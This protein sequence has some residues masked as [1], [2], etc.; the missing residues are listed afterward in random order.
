MLTIVAS[1][2]VLPTG[3]A[4]LLMY[5]PQFIFA[6][7]S[8]DPVG[9]GQPVLIVTWTSEMAMPAD[10][11]PESGAPGGRECWTGMS[12]TITD[13]DG[14]T[15]NINMPPSDPVGANYYAYTPDKSG[16][17][18]VVTHIPGQWKNRTA[19][20]PYGSSSWQIYPAGSYYFEPADSNPVTFTVQDEQLQ[21]VPGVPLPTEYWTR[22]I[23]GY[24]REWAQIA[25]NWITGTRDDP[26]ITTPDTAHVVWTEPYFYGGIAGG[27]FES[28]SFYEGTSYE[29]K[30]SG[31]TI[32]GGILF[33]NENLASSSSYTSV[34][35]RDLRTGEVL[36]RL[37]NSRVGD[38]VIYDYES[39]NQHG[40]H[41][42]LWSGNSILDPFSGT[43]LFRYINVPSGS[44]AIGPNGEY[45]KYVFGGPTS[46]NTIT[47]RPTT[48]VTWLAL[49]NFSTPLSMTGIT[50][51]ELAYYYATGELV[52]TNY[53]QWRPVGKTH[54]GTLGYSWN[55]TVPSGLRACT[56]NIAVLD[57]RII[58]GEGWMQFGIASPYE[59]FNLWALSTKAGSRGNVLWNTWIKPPVHNM[60]L[61]FNGATHCSLA[62]GIFLVRVKEARTWMAFD[63]DTG[64]YLWTTSEPEPEW[65]MYSSDAQFYDGKF[66]TGGYGGEIFAYDAATGDRL[67]TA[68]VD[69]EGLESAYVRSPISLQ[70][71]D[72]KV[73]ARSQEHSFTHPY[74]RTWR[75]YCFNA[76]TGDRIW[77]LNGGWSAAA[78]SDGFMAALNYYDGLVYGIGKGPSAATVGA[79]PKISTH[80]SSVMIEGMVTDVSAGTKSNRIAP[81]FPNGVPAVS[82]ESM[83]AWMEYVYMQKPKPADATGVE[84]VISV[85]DPNNNVYEVGRTTSDADG[86]FKLAFEPL[87]P[88]EYTVIATFEGSESYYGSHAVTAINVEEAPAATAEPTPTPAPMTDTYVLGL[89][90]AAIIAIVVIGIVL[91]LMLRKR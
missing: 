28:N 91:I 36:W 87:V 25:G 53:D 83:T 86:F 14:N 65:M 20:L 7:V 71:Y 88:G 26:Y 75:V 32:I 6:A 47:E 79:S 78:F 42:Y 57:D 67:W 38:S 59:K 24:N 51:A 15:Q 43:E 9:I 72:G 19:A 45:L 12:L 70:I 55:V 60:T 23:N 37:N 81:R 40:L 76:T 77:D 39:R 63:I 54:N 82:D 62:D 80:G 21:G 73:F 31:A 5:R 4:Q 18:T 22:P 2:V 44:T 8:P 3:N 30:F 52:G 50:S 66:Y 48:N 27:A 69:N 74:Y 85:L 13:P 11:D 17:Y 10:N 35:A 16:N 46:G 49:W 1:M 56:S 41:P 34:V 68:A 90:T 61:Q 64:A 33:Y 29:G 89:G 84:V 58:A